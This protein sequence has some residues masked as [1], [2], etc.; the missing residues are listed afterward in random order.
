MAS[1]DHIQFHVGEFF[2]TATDGVPRQVATLQDIS[3]NF[4]ADVKELYGAG[5]FSVDAA[6]GTKSITGKFTSGEFDMLAINAL[7]FN[8]TPTVGA[9]LLVRDEPGLT[10]GDSFTVVGAADFDKDLGVKTSTGADLVRVAAAPA[11]GQYA[12]SS[13]GEY[14]FNAAVADGTRFFFS[15]IKRTATGTTVSL[16]NREAGDT[17]AFEGRFWKKSRTGKQFGMIA[18][19]CIMSSLDLSFKQNDYMMPA[20]EFTVT[21]PNVGHILQFVRGA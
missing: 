19:A 14:T 12:V 6:T 17:V 5:Q 9:L 15:Y 2:T 10:A 21:T 8:E 4:K 11:E 16:N 18:P 7:L 3:F 1:K 13:T 20:S